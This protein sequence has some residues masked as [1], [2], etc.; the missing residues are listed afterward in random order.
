MRRWIDICFSRIRPL[1]DPNKRAPEEP[2]NCGT[3]LQNKLKSTISSFILLKIL[4]RKSRRDAGGLELEQIP[5]RRQSDASF[6]YRAVLV[7]HLV[8]V[9]I[10]KCNEPIQADIERRVRL[11]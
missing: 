2:Q 7:I 6:W 11:G 3:Q 10:K 4:V 1:V 5:R 9:F 8:H